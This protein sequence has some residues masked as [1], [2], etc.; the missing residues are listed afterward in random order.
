M[1]VHSPIPLQKS[2]RFN[3]LVRIPLGSPTLYFLIKNF[4][5]EKSLHS[6]PERECTSCCY[7]RS[8]ISGYRVS[9]PMYYFQLRNV[10]NPYQATC[11]KI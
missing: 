2:Q 11:K 8:C 6:V 5:N 4:V 9:F 7:Y 1:F 10:D 3:N